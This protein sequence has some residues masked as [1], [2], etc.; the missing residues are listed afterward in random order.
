MQDEEIMS[1]AQHLSADDIE[2][3][4]VIILEGDQQDT[5]SIDML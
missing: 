1:D 3:E 4:R 5:F 2:D